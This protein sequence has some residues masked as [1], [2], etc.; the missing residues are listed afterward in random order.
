MCLRV[1]KATRAELGHLAYKAGDD[2]PFTLAHVR[3]IL[4]D[5]GRA[6]FDNI[7][8]RIIGLGREDN[9]QH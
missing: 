9:C 2:A 8:T 4:T 3:T 5:F 1:R 6:C 7:S